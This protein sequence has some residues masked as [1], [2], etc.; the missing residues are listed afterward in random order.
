MILCAMIMF[1][2]CESFAPFGDAAELLQAKTF[3]LFVALIDSCTDFS[4]S[5]V[6]AK[7]RH[8]HTTNSEHSIQAIPQSSATG[9]YLLFRE[10][11]SGSICTAELLRKYQFL[12]SQSTY[13]QQT[14]LFA[15]RWR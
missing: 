5:S 3:R 6:T 12:A 4:I 14:R 10:Q 2:V 8:V 7:T 11:F 13:V 1:I 9:R 15:Y